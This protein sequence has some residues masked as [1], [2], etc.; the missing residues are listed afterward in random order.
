MFL[1]ILI[2]V[3]A[4]YFFFPKWGHMFLNYQNILFYERWSEGHT[5]NY[6]ENR[7][8]WKI[9]NFV[10]LDMSF[11]RKLLVQKCQF[12]KWIE[13]LRWSKDFTQPFLKSWFFRIFWHLSTS[14]KILLFLNLIFT[15]K[16]SSLSIS[17][18][19]NQIRKLK[20]GMHLPANVF[21]KLNL[22]FLEILIL[23][24]VIALQILEN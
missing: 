5:I 14:A 17:S 18:F 13:I 22:A 6:G 10:H 21:P 20:I 7:T 4:L 1:F 16:I 2:F 15:G 11:F 12:C 24:P 8:F 9:A 23:L 19:K 3:I